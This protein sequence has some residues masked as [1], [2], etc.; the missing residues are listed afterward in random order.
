VIHVDNCSICKSQAST[1]WLKEYNMRHMPHLLYLSDLVSSDFYLCPT[2]KVKL[3][4]IQVR[5]KDKLFECL[6]E[7]VK[8]INHDELNRIF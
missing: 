4:K 2:V 1:D 3:E 5:Q 8:D 7:I 6:Q